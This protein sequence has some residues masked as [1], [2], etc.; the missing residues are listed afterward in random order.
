MDWVD[1]PSNYVV[2]IRISLAALA[3]KRTIKDW[4]TVLI[5]LVDDV[6][7]LLLLLLV[8]WIFDI[9]IPL[10]I[11]I[12]IALLFGGFVFIIHKA[13]IP[14]LH[15]KQITGSEGMIGLTGEVV[16]PLIPV[17]MVR[18]RGE[19]WKAKSVGE[20]IAVSEEVEI[21]SLNGLTLMV[22]PK[23]QSLRKFGDE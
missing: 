9:Q 21:L 10:P 13:V 14:V 16:E 8:L 15:K 18:V 23:N 7:A 6:A 12:V 5:L 20:N 1:Y 4:F 17:G 3:M 19:N 22:K 2:I 11:T